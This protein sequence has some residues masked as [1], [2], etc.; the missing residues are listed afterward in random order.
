MATMDVA[1]RYVEL[2]KENKHDE[3]LNELFAKD[4]VSVEAGAPPGQDRTAAE[5]G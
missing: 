5:D 1:K 3:C 4:A 2:V